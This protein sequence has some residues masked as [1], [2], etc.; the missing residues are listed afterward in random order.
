MQNWIITWIGV[1]VSFPNMGAVISWW[2]T[3]ANY[4]DDTWNTYV[5]DSWNTYTNN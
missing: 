4:V 1:W 2:S 3:T 5:D